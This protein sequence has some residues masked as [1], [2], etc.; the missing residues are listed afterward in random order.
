MSRKLKSFNA[1]SISTKTRSKTKRGN[2]YKLHHQCFALNIIWNLKNNKQ[3]SLRPALLLYHSSW[4][5]WERNRGFLYDILA[6][7]VT[8]TKKT[9]TKCR[10]KALYSCILH[11][12]TITT[13]FI[14]NLSTKQKCWTTKIT[15]NYYNESMS[16]FCGSC[17]MY[18]NG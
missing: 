18:T 6:A 14:C 9:V 13:T 4:N 10:T 5:A 17:F 15:F 12:K 7:L 1:L 11:Q 16:T 8:W 2:P 3:F